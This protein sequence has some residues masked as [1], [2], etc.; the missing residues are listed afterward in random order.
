MFLQLVWDAPARAL[1]DLTA[2]DSESDGHRD[3]IKHWFGISGSKLRQ[4]KNQQLVESCAI[5]GQW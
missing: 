4:G 2:L 5:I 3:E 1:E